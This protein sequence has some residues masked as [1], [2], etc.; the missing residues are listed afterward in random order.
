MIDRIQDLDRFHRLYPHLF[1]RKIGLECGAGWYPLLDELFIVLERCIAEGMESGQWQER[2]DSGDAHPWP[3]ALQI[4]EKFG[5]LRVY[6]GQRPPEMSAA[7]ELA[8]RRAAITCDQCGEPGSLRR[9]S[10][11]LCTRCELHGQDRG[12]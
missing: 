8:L 11:Y 4:K 1:V 9:L 10:G 7:I 6:I 2:I 3:H 12:W 5:G